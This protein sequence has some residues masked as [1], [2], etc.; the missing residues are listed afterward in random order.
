MEKQGCTPNYS[1]SCREASYYRPWK[2]ITNTYRWCQPGDLLVAGFSQDHLDFIG[3]LVLCGISWGVD[4][5]IWAHDSSF[6]S[7]LENIVDLRC[8]FGC[9]GHF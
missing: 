3:V 5:P 4:R 7:C 1:L 9:P 6:T 8:W 2:P